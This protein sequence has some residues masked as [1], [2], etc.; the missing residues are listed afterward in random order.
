MEFNFIFRHLTKYQK[1]SNEF[2]SL[3]FSIYTY[4]RIM[5]LP[6]KMKRSY[7]KMANQTVL[8]VG[9]ILENSQ[10]KAFSPKKKKL[11]YRVMKCALLKV[12]GMRKP[13]LLSQVV[14]CSSCWKIPSM[15]ISDYNKDVKLIKYNAN[16]KYL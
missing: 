9:I 5:K 2:C 8:K 6:W 12:T 13:G 16:S 15:G 14:L 10:F 4:R 1:K 11:R 7:S 3:L